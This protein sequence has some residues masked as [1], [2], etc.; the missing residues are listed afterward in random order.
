MSCALPGLQRERPGPHVH[1]AYHAGA[2]HAAAE[3]RAELQRR[4]FRRRAH[5]PVV[6]QADHREQLRRPRG[7]HRDPQGESALGAS[8]GAVEPALTWRFDGPQV[9]M[10]LD[11]EAACNSEAERHEALAATMLDYLT[12]V[13]SP[14]QN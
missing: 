14:L 4:P 10:E 9:V 1:A 12:Q 5:V 8:V 7:P 2:P 3:E 13:S 11:M 6:V